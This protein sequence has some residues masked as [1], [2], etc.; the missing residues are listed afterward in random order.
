MH[1]E[2]VIFERG[3][4]TPKSALQAADLRDAPLE[5]APKFLTSRELAAYLRYG[6]KTPECSANK[7]TKRHGLR[8]YWRNR[9]ALVMR[10]DVDAVLEGRHAS[11]VQG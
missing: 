5:T 3:H 11:T 9:T 6:G 7:F 2:D 1:R 10:A 8:R 4:R